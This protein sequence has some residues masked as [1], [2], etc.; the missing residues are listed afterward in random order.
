M[1]RVS[2]LLTSMVTIARVAVAIEEIEVEQEGTRQTASDRLRILSEALEHYTEPYDSEHFYEH[3]LFPNAKPVNV[4]VLPHKF[5]DIEWA[6]YAVSGDRPLVVRNSLVSQWP[7]FRKWNAAYFVRHFA[8]K[9]RMHLSEE[10]VLRMHSDVQP[11]ASQTA[12][13]EIDWKRPWI[14]GDVRIGTLFGEKYV[15]RAPSKSWVGRLLAGAFGGEDDE[16]E[17]EKQGDHKLFFSSI[18]HGVPDSIRN[19]VSD[20]SFLVQPWRKVLEVNLWS[21]SNNITTPL[22]YDVTHNFYVQIRGRKRFVLFPPKD[23]RKLYL[24]PRVHPSSRSSQIAAQMPDVDTK[25]FPDFEGAQPYEVVLEA[26][27][28]LFIPAYWFHQPTAITTTAADVPMVLRQTLEEAA[29]RKDGDANAAAND[30]LHLMRESATSDALLQ[31]AE[32]PSISVS[33]CSESYQVQIREDMLDYSL[34]IPAEWSFVKKVGVV[35]AYIPLFFR[36]EEL[37]RRYLGEVWRNR[38]ANFADD[39]D[40]EG[41]VEAQAKADARFRLLVQKKGVPLPPAGLRKDLERQAMRLIDDVHS[42]IRGFL[43]EEWEIELANYIE[44]IASDVLGPLNV[45]PFFKY[46]SE[47]AF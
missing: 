17:D 14:E 35:K 7:A 46:Y 31:Y 20:V 42:A 36:S 47:G 34:P 38:F 29:A 33:V 9:I 25:S 23:W 30:L 6:D 37:A 44:D 2:L 15:Q 24:F 27:D 3:R 39:P 16:D 1:L 5:R 12:A 26:G 10:P 18:M 4:T 8:P 43:P 19:D 21:G 41:L 40:V 13:G 11:L 32:M 22:H 28:V 45:G